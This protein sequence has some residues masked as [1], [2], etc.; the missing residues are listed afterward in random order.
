VRIAF[1]VPRCIPDN[2]HGRYVIELASRF[3]LDNDVTVYSGAFCPALTARVRRRFLPIVDWPMVCRLATTWAASLIVRIQTRDIVHVQGADAPFGTVV[4]AHCCTAAMDV[5]SPSPNFRQRV[6]HT[7]G[8][9]AERLSFAKSSTR[10]VIAVSSKV[11]D[12]VER[13]Y[14]VDKHKL[15]VVTPGVDLEMFHPARLESRQAGRQ[16]LGLSDHDFVI[17]FV[18]GNF[19]LKGLLPLLEALRRLDQRVTVVAVGV[20]PTTELSAVY[21]QIVWI[22]RTTDIA[23]YY[24]IADCFVLPTLYDTFSLVTLEAMASGLPV[25]VSKA[26]G[27]SDL[28]T[29]GMNALLLDDPTD[30]DA[31]AQRVDR[32]MTDDR[33]R[34]HLAKHARRF[35]EDR[36]WDRVAAETFEI[37]RTVYSG[38]K[39]TI[40]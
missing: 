12:E 8:A 28:L 27:I 9:W 22:E 4:T 35:A 30:V 40:G 3:A 19:R 25:I 2:S 38:A 34:V 18:G 17:L 13:H 39:E 16:G 21:Q 37:Y 11:R 33:L 10:A 32:L 1:V 20:T 6:N 14:Q 26:A 31:L 36:S 23:R 15:T 5:A 29:D 7:L 24:S